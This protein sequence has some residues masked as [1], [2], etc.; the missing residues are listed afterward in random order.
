MPTVAEIKS[1]V[2]HV[3]HV[4]TT[5]SL[6][7]YSSVGMGVFIAALYFKICFKDFA[8]FR[9]SVDS[10]IEWQSPLHL[11]LLNWDALK[12]IIW[13][14]LSVGAGFLAHHQLP[15]WFPRLFH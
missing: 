3:W 8:G 5:A 2:I 11:R 7:A 1:Y 4:A 6:L 9:D 14:L 13:V 12:L 10:F 15:Q